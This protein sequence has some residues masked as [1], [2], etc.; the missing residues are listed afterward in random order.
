[1]VLIS[2]VFSLVVNL[3]DALQ[4]VAHILKEAFADG[5]C[6]LMGTCVKEHGAALG[7]FGASQGLYVGLPLVQNVIPT[8]LGSGFR[9]DQRLGWDAKGV[10]LN[11][12]LLDLRGRFGHRAK[13]DVGAL[14]G[15]IFKK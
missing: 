5:C 9:E 8:T 6:H 14:I 10:G 1:M 11:H 4:R 2:Y 12:Q 13:G 7:R 3:P 15:K